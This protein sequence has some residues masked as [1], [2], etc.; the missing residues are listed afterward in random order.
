MADTNSSGGCQGCLTHR[1]LLVPLLSPLQPHR[2]LESLLPTPPPYS[3]IPRLASVPGSWLNPRSAWASLAQRRPYALF[4]AASFFY[5]P[6]SF[7]LTRL[8][9]PRADNAR[10]G[11]HSRRGC[12]S[13]PRW[14]AEA[15]GDRR[16]TRDGTG[17]APHCPSPG[18][19]APP[20]SDRPKSRGDREEWK[21]HQENLFKAIPHYPAANVKR[22]RAPALPM[23]SFTPGA[24]R[25]ARVAQRRGCREAGGDAPHQRHCST[26]AKPNPAC[27]CLR[28]SCLGPRKGPRRLEEEGTTA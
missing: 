6:R 28:P 26:I 23:T 4:P 13:Q 3:L 20:A 16:A 17:A 19:P 10:P 18:K 25:R 11:C 14:G 9:A 12:T 1:C 7:R 21:S 15:A 8:P 24:A 5:S 2:L 22:E 27:L